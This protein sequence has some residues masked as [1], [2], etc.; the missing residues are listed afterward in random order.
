MFT[1]KLNKRLLVYVI[2]VLDLEALAA[3]SILWEGLSPYAFTPYPQLL[4]VLEKVERCQNLWLI[5][6][7]PL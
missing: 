7:A 4:Q 2:P 3:L 6:L 5:L 1:T